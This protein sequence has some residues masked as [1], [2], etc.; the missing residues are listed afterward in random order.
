MDSSRALTGFCAALLAVG[1][2]SG[3]ASAAPADPPPRAPS[4][5]DFGN[6]PDRNEVAAT[7]PEVSAAA[8][9]DAAGQ[10]RWRPK[11]QGYPRHTELR[12][13]PETPPTGR[14]SWAWCPITRSR[15]G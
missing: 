5:R 15:P 10:Q 6:G 12:V 11:R 13:Y 3:P 9:L 7:A 4:T 2:G 1:L 8:A 14:S